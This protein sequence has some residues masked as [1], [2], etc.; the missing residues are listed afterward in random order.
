M[1][2]IILMFALAL[3]ACGSSDE[4]QARVAPDRVDPSSI[5]LDYNTIVGEQKTSPTTTATSSST[6]PTATSTATTPIPCYA[7][8]GK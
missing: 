4:E 6:A 8:L 1:K 2:T 7:C 3:V 5:Y